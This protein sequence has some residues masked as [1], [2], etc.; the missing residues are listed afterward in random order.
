MPGAAILPGT[1]V[2]GRYRVVALVGRGGMG[3]VYRA[4]DL[5][6]G[7]AVA[8]KFLPRSVERE[9]SWLAKLLDEVRIARQ[10]SHPSVCRV[11]DVGEADGRHFLTMEFIDG[12][13]LASLL[14][15]IGRVPPE[16]AVQ[17][18]RQLCAGLA[19]AHDQR[20]LHR[21]LKPA[22]VMI[23]GRGRAR[24]TDFGLAG[25]QEA[26]PREEVGA[27]TPAY[28]AP[29]Q[30]A[31]RD[32][33]VRSDVY[34][35]GL[36]LYELF[37]GR[38]AFEGAGS[39]QEL[40]E[41]RSGPP[42][43]PSSH[44]EELDPDVERV[45]LRCLEP[46][47]ALRPSSALAVAA[48]LPGGDP[49]A[50][51]LAA[52]ETPAPE[53]VAGASKEG[54]LRRGAAAGALVGALLLWSA[55][56]VLTTLPLRYLSFERPPEALADRARELLARLGHTEKP[57]D[58]AWGYWQDE[59]LRLRLRH[60]PPAG[61]VAAARQGH[62]PVVEFWYRE[63]GDYLVPHD[64]NRV[65]WNNPPFEAPGARRLSM[66]TDGRLLALRAVP[67]PAVE[68]MPRQTDWSALLAAA[69]LDAA[70]LAPTTPTATPPDFADTRAAWLAPAAGPAGVRLRV[71]AAAVGGVPVYFDAA[72]DLPAEATAPPAAATA[73]QRFFYLLLLTLLT[74]VLAAAVWLARRNLKAAR[75]DRRGAMVVA[76]VVTGLQAVE[77]VVSASHAPVL[78]EFDLF[79]RS[80][81][82]AL[83]LAGIV[84]LLY[85]ALEPLLRRRSPASLVA[86]TRLLAGRPRDPLVGRDLLLGAL[87]GAAAVSVGALHRVAQ[88]WT[89][90]DPAPAPEDVAH[91]I[92]VPGLFGVCSRAILVPFV[93]G[94]GFL[95][96]WQLFSWG[97]RSSKRGAIALGA[98][99]L[100]GLSVRSGVG[101]PTPFLLAQV[102]LMVVAV[103]R[104]GL[105]ATMT[106]FVVWHLGIFFPL[107]SDPSAWFF[108]ESLV[109]FVLGALPAIWGGWVA[110][111]GS[112]SPSAA[113]A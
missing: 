74:S 80:A 22:N 84:W 20:V 41:R 47:P 99:L 4:D 71:E 42:P 13:D 89:G 54:S 78:A 103:S 87:L 38:P 39:L 101:M 50:A 113:T 27:G 112:P 83:F 45:I 17:I 21:D 33:T 44:V 100:F 79:F 55:A 51:A 72:P 46:D 62:A 66:T 28:M 53:V 23:D 111:R 18:A 81:A 110:T 65:S 40:R 49:L 43:A 98:L 70:E 96:L 16:K 64:Q 108:G 36:V 5:K 52:G 48:A 58:R 57:V 91:L 25:L 77:W 26:I 69:D 68:P 61:L 24:I 9:G 32:V 105:L 90:R 95:V 56:F 97:L 86:W 3:E 8:L 11:Y 2:A 76:A 10:I 88:W 35:L 85:I 59:G 106:M 37:A 60:Q 73:R 12:E 31:G 67:V 107:W 104:L 34:A 6:L 19:A 15:R 92:G 14:R 30:L 109:V 93:N 82:R 75:A 29:E 1:I 63:G 102:V 7:Q 94:M